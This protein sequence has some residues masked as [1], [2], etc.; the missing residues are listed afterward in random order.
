VCTE[1][2][3]DLKTQRLR[4]F[5]ETIIVSTMNLFSSPFLARI[6]SSFRTRAALQAE[7]LSLRHHVVQA[8]TK[9]GI[10]DVQIQSVATRV[11]VGLLGNPGL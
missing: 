2:L 5:R 11:E 6:A 7:L 4:A 3:S 8:R 10:Q 9:R 1:S